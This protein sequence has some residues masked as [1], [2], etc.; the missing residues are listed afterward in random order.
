MDNQF[1]ESEADHTIPK[2]NC[3]WQFGLKT[4]DT[5]KGHSWFSFPPAYLPGMDLGAV[6]NHGD[7]VWGEERD[8]VIYLRDIFIFCHTRY[9]KICRS[10]DLAK[11]SGGHQPWRQTWIL[12]SSICRQPLYLTAQGFGSVSSTSSNEL[13]KDHSTY[14]NWEQ[15]SHTSRTC[16]AATTWAW[17][18]VIFWFLQAPL[19]SQRDRIPGSNWG[20]GIE[21]SRNI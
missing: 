12:I 1:L 14:N 9:L 19:V 20:L 6:K 16:C 18:K 3:R 7:G 11:K 15:V 8:G 17:M 10:L 5:S 2:P 4:R 13:S 21:V